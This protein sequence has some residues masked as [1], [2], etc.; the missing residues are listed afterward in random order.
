[1]RREY[2]RVK[3]A[4]VLAFV[5]LSWTGGTAL[6][7]SGPIRLVPGQGS[8]QPGAPVP[9]G[10][11]GLT[12]Q[13]GFEVGVPQRGIE[14]DAIAVPQSVTALSVSAPGAESAGIFGPGSGGY[15]PDLWTGSDRG[16]LGV[17]LNHL[18]KDAGSAALRGLMRRVLGTSAVMPGDGGAG[19]GED[20]LRLRVDGLLEAGHAAD[21]AGLIDAAGYAAAERLAPQAARAALLRF[22]L[23][24]ACGLAA[25]RAG[26]PDAFWRRLVV[27]CHAA[28]G[29]TDQAQLGQTMLREAGE[30]DPLLNWAIDRLLGVDAGPVP[31]LAGG[32]PDAVSLAAIRLTQGSLPV[33]VVETLGPAE[34]ALLA[35]AED[36]DPEMRL[37]AAERAAAAGAIPPETVMAAYGAYPLPADAKSQPLSAAHAMAG[38]E[39][40]ALLAQTA[41]AETVPSVRAELVAAFLETVHGDALEPALSA[42]MV[43]M[44]DGL[45]TGPESGFLA[46]AGLRASLLAGKSES[47]WR[48]RS[49]LVPAGADE[50]GKQS[51]RLW[52]AMRLGFGANGADERDRPPFLANLLADRDGLGAARLVRLV[53]L[54]AALGDVVG[55]AE[56][57]QSITRDRTAELSFDS[58]SPRAV[59]AAGMMRRAVSTERRGEAALAA[60]LSADGRK[61]GRIPTE[62]MAAILRGLTEAGFQAE[63]RLLALEAAFGAGL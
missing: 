14:Q 55:D 17:L 57:S 48:W 26:D 61:A 30:M 36:I 25:T 12:A 23:P 33:S 10:Q 21:A 24:A 44:L 49:V 41:A 1:M 39:A 32:Q 22:D 13:P 47:A 7:Q 46:P 58:P 62:E 56:W 5:A 53:R 43:P 27:F 6:G 63:A 16:T 15:G 38:P 11:P 42:A 29:A 28:S 35:G 54:R 59:A 40:R 31:G 52:G 3:A 4:L 19:A 51:A 9:S 20:L 45:P 34:A 2:G 60:I 8:G 18:P 50:A 37:I